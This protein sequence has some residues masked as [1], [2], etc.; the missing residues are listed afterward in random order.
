MAYLLLNI[1]FAFQVSENCI[2]DLIDYERGVNQLIPHDKSPYFNNTYSEMFYYSGHDLND[3][4]NYLKCNELD[5]AK[6]VLI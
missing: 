4:G 6:Y 5:T 2:Q 1:S 3:L